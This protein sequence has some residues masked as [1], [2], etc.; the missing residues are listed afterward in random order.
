[1]DEFGHFNISF[2]SISKVKADA[3][4]TFITKMPDIGE[5]EFAFYNDEEE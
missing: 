2:P 3:I 4:Q 5:V 1:M